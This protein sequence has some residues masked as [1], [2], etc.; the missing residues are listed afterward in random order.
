M[1]VRIRRG[2]DLRFAGAPR[3]S[4]EAAPTVARVAILGADYPGLR[5]DVLA[6]AGETVLAGQPLLRDRKHPDRLVVA[7]VAGAITAVTRGARRSIATIEIA[8][9][10]NARK[11]FTLPATL[12]RDH[13][14]AL[15]L[16]SGLWAAIRARPFGHAAELAAMPEALFITAMDTRPHAPD[17][18]AV[19]AAHGGW[20]AAG[21]AA[22]TRLTTGPT[23]LCQADG[24]SI[25]VSNGLTPARFAGRH[26]AGL[27]STHIHHLHP[28]KRPG[29]L[30]WQVNYQEVIALGHLLETGGIWSERIIAVSGPALSRPALLR[31][32]PGAELHLLLAGR[33]PPATPRVMSGSAIDGRVQPFLSRSDLQVFAAP[34][35]LPA[36]GRSKLH[37]LIHSW[38]TAGIPALIPN[39]A[40][41]RAAPIGLLPIPFLRA[42]SVG[43]SEM[44]QK[45]GALELVEEDLALLTHVDN[46]HTDFGA[47]LRAVLDELEGAR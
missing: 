23:Y 27:A 21:A 30:V 18:S 42:L 1:V 24:S 36:A 43:D 20:F 12:D 11:D 14:A 28:V 15:L 4:I 47:M 8:P 37:Q 26:P 41:E 29:R 32:P 45:L 31:T 10:G 25:T 38:Q 6:E 19:I 44:A 7:P 9:S 16:E 35:R 40:H 2:V 13:L 46:S 33:L 5:F 17:P 34:H 3:Q 22:L 39:T